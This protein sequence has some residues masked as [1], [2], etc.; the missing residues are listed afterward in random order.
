MKEAGVRFLAIGVVTSEI[1]TI[2]TLFNWANSLQNRT[3]YLVVRNHRNGD[4]FSEGARIRAIELTHT[5]LELAISR[6][7]DAPRQSAVKDS[8]KAGS[9]RY[10]SDRNS[11]QEE[12]T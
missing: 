11:L 1:A 6:A 12:E 2:E 5:A 4:D 7:N 8:Q 3:D 10:C 9:K